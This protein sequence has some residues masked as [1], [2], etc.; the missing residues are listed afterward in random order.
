M[1]ALPIEARLAFSLI[2]NYIFRSQAVNIAGLLEGCTVDWEFFKRFISYHSISPFVFQL[3]DETSACVPAGVKFFLK[4]EYY[5]FMVRSQRL[6]N[7]YLRIHDSFEKEGIM[8]VP[9]QGLAF[10]ADIYL[11]RPYRAMRDIDLL[12]KQEDFHNV[13]RVLAGLGYEKALGGFSE[14]FWLEHQC[15]LMFKTNR[16]DMTY[17]VELH[18][19]RDTTVIPHTTMSGA[20]DRL[21]TA[22]LNGRKLFILSIEYQILCLAIHQRRFGH[23]MSVK[24]AVD[25]AFLLRK[26]SGVMDWDLLIAQARKARLCSS[27]AFLLLRVQVFLGAPVPAGLLKALGVSGRTADGLRAF[28]REN[29]VMLGRNY[30]SLLKAHFLLHDSVKDSIN[31]I[32][33]MPREQFAGFYDMKPDAIV[34][35][36]FYYFRIIY[37]GVRY[38]A[39]VCACF[40]NR[41]SCY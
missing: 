39:G 13:C 18:F 5:S 1:K 20:L 38:F 17:L 24:N 26:Y 23:N 9:L 16:R 28:S 4:D 14:S 2:R 36:V 10:L 25:L 40:I 33:R 7:E 31:Y 15:G 8:E 41:K 22:D 30:N 6:W 29:A 37:M 27:L 3:L 12:I 32:L 19:C 34:T 11:E 21:R 35:Y